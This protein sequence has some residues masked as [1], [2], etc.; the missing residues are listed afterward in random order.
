M[1][2]PVACSAFSEP[3]KRSTVS[4]QNASMKAA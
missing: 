3:S 2:R 4:R 1:F